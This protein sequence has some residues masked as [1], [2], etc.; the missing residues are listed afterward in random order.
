MAASTTIVAASANRYRG[1]CSARGPEGHGD[2][3]QLKMALLD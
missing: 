2:L 3:V 1:K